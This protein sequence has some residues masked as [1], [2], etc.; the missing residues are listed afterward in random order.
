M[1]LVERGYPRRHG[2][3]GMKER[4]YLRRHTAVSYLDAAAA[5]NG[6]IWARRLFVVIRRT[7]SLGGQRFVHVLPDRD[8]D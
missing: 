7:L 8:L 4:R 2:P 1:S 5:M 6:A 3:F